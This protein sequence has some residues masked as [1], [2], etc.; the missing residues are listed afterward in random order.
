M[1]VTWSGV[2]CVCGGGGGGVC[3]GGLVCVFCD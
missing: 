2:W 1:C 3:V